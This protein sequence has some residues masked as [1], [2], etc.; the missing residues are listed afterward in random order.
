MYFIRLNNPFKTAGNQIV[1][2]K[3]V[4][5]LLTLIR[6]TYQSTSC[7]YLHLTQYYNL[8]KII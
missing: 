7:M 8:F 5:D 3:T 1:L 6:K 2:K 4:L